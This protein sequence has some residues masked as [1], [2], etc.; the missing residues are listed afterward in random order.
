MEIK[1]KMTL[2]IIQNMQV[3]QILE[4]CKL[5]DLRIIKELNFRVRIKEL[6]IQVKFK[7]IMKILPKV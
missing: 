2:V 5:L 7:T 4:C 1:H 3:V 6:N